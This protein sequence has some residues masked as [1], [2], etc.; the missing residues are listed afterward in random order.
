MDCRVA[1]KLG[2][3]IARRVAAEPIQ[4][5][6]ATD[7]GILVDAFQPLEVILAVGY[8]EFSHHLVRNPMFGAVGFEQAMSGHAEDR[9]RSVGPVVEAGVRDLVAA[10]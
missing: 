3:E 7:V 9:L 1:S 8:D 4:T 2:F 10:G 6:C 5:P